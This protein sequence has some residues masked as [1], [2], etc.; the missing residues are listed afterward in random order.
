[1]GLIESS[2][3]RHFY[4]TRPVQ[5]LDSQKKSVGGYAVARLRMKDTYLR[6]DQLIQSMGFQKTAPVSTD[7]PPKPYDIINYVNIS[8]ASRNG[9]VNEIGWDMQEWQKQAAPSSEDNPE[10]ATDNPE[11]A[12]Y[13]V[14]CTYKA[15]TWY[16]T[17]ISQKTAAANIYG[18]TW[19]DPYNE[20][21][22]YY[23]AKPGSVHEIKHRKSTS[24]Y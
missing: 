13:K 14:I 2:S 12:T 9:W 1:M 18:S 22:A 5:F 24:Y 16:S 15:S 6:I 3:Y 20:S 21:T 4:I 10:N 23:R 17:T 8:A 7:Q 11:N 19:V